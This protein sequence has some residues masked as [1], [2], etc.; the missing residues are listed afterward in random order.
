MK[1][2]QKALS[3]YL[4]AAARSGDRA[5]ADRVARLHGPRLLAHA[6]R[7][8][9]EREV[10][11]DIVQDAWLEIWRSLPKLQE[12]DA[13]LPW[14]LR[15]VSRRVARQILTRQKQRALA[16]KATLLADDI[17][18][19]AAAPSPETVLDAASEAAAVHAA[20]AALPPSHRACVALFYLEDMR[21]AD[22]AAAMDV[23][24]GT[25]KT[26]LMHARKKLRLALKG[27][28]DE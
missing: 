21:V 19:E 12:V 8:M 14:A 24:V 11:R 28:D 7:L 4:V 27:D 13:F 10:A 20:L 3:A 1:T 15:I 5:A 25:I 6:T 17:A 23:P 2:S 22:V 26:R 16:E 18:P 9:G